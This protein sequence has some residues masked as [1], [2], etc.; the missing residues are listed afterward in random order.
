MSTSF[1]GPR[2]IIVLGL[3][4]WIALGAQPARAA[5]GPAA[6]AV[7]AEEPRVLATEVFQGGLLADGRLLCTH[8]DSTFSVLNLASGEAQPWLPAWS[9][10]PRTAGTWRPTAAFAGSLR[11]SPDGRHVA[12]AKVVGVTHQDPQ[13]D[14]P[15]FAVAIVL[16]DPTGADA[17]CVALADLSDGGPQLDFTQDS[18]RLVGPFFYP[19]LPTAAG[20]MA[21]AANGYVATA[22]DYNYIDTATGAGGMLPELP[23]YEFYTKAPLSD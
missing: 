5:D 4:A 19:C 8:Y 21:Y 20:L 13:G 23:D 12:L 1:L 10:L 16:S 11:V 17:R 15:D 14:Y 7:A 6:P 18:A 9:P 3:A 2:G 22:A